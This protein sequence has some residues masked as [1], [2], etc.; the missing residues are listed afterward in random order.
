MD[1]GARRCVGPVAHGAVPLLLLLTVALAGCIGLPAGAPHGQDC[2]TL[3]V[4]HPRGGDRYSYQATG[5]LN[6]LLA[7]GPMAVDWTVVGANESSTL[8]LPE[9]ST[10]DVVVAE[11]PRPVLTAGGVT[12]TA[13][14]VSYWVTRADIGVPLAFLDQWISA[15]DATMVQNVG[16]N[17]PNPGP[18][19]NG[20]QHLVHFSR[21]GR[22]TLFL[23]SLYWGASLQAG[24]AGIHPYTWAIVADG[25]KTRNVTWTVLD[26]Y[27]TP[28]GCRAEVSADFTIGANEMQ[29]LE[30]TRLT[31]SDRVPVPVRYQ[32]I[33]SP[34][35]PKMR[36][37]V[38]ELARYDAGPG[39]PLPTPSVRGLG[40]ALPTAPHEG[41]FLPGRGGVFPTDY[42]EAVQAMRD[43]ASMG[44][45]LKNHPGARPVEVIHW[46][47]SPDQSSPTDPVESTRIIDQWEITW[48]PTDG[49]DFRAA[50]ATRKNVS[51]L[52]VEDGERIDVEDWHGG[53]EPVAPT[54]DT[55]PTL[56]RL[57]DLH[58]LIYG[59]EPETL[60]CQ[61]EEDRRECW[62]GTHEGTGL[63]YADGGGGGPSIPGVRVSLSTGY[64]IAAQSFGPPPVEPLPLD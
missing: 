23:S 39:A 37:S 41:H 32:E 17:L 5:K 20:V 62:I 61:V 58:Q 33:P 43:D 47:G 7:G 52:L 59:E 48:A 53:L 15:G 2:R 26:T 11:D 57:A 21:R 60:V 36:G 49:D 55:L 30:G 18:P 44:E 12:E 24:D 22:P 45:W 3:E 50:T 34:D 29:V 63:P 13:Y 27:A 54:P 25:V 9:G 19:G 51:G 28:D 1:R 40:P 64:L 4:P 56:A 31:L 16:R 14:Q 46:L 10:V 42:D 35:F 6:M 38:L 8:D